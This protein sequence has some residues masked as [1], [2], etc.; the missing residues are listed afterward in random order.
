M[1]SHP[2]SDP[3]DRARSMSVA[4]GLRSRKVTF[5]AD[6]SPNLAE[7]T[8]PPAA[9][10]IRPRGS[11]RSL[12]RSR[13]M[14][15]R[16]LEEPPTDT[17]LDKQPPSL[18]IPRRPSTSAFVDPSLDSR[19]TSEDNVGSKRFW[20]SPLRSVTIRGPRRPSTS[21][22]VTH[23]TSTDRPNSIFNPDPNRLHTA[24]VQSAPPVTPIPTLVTP[25]ESGPIPR[26]VPSVRRSASTPK[27]LVIDDK[28]S[29]RRSMSLFQ[30]SHPAEPQSELSST[31][32]LPLSSRA[33]T[34]VST[35]KPS[36]LMR[37]LSQSLLSSSS[38]T[39]MAVPSAI[40]RPSEAV[41]NRK[42][43]EVVRSLS[44]EFAGSG[45]GPEAY[46][47]KMMHS[48]NPA[49]VAGI[50]AGRYA[51]AKTGSEF[52]AEHTCPPARKRS[53][54][55]PSRLT[56]GILTSIT[57]LWTSRCEDYFS[58][59]DY[60][61][62]LN[63]SIALLVRLRVGTKTAT[64]ECSQLQVCLLFLTIISTLK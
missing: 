19:G 35:S 11:S 15:G 63:K 55:M 5:E 62:K 25:P 49:E 47:R 46:V 13:S 23:H 18:D 39:Q 37:K 33:P 30:R 40:Q 6:S 9:P 34:P 44:A 38:K 3:S 48:V 60:L 17:V 10:T 29:R 26:K 27:L 43:A 54:L 4:S 24:E 2:P 56:C 12:F 7:R 50:L 57:S 64:S 22:G 14:Y 1:L 61:K 20:K 52:I 41:A 36:P 8:D 59:F 42:Q 58:R 31:V 51:V 32:T 53:K 28:P 21:D 16:A 45:Q